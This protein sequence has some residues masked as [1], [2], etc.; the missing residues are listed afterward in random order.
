MVMHSAKSEIYI[1]SNNST[2][3]NGS[4]KL[5]ELPLKKFSEYLLKYNIDLIGFLKTSS[6]DS[7]TIKE[8]FNKLTHEIHY[9]GL[10]CKGEHSSVYKEE[11]FVDKRDQ[12]ILLARSEKDIK[13]AMG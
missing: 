7:S 4:K 11:I 2:I 1:Y 8:G 3:K 10:L 5:K 9:V 12:F 13:S 6:D